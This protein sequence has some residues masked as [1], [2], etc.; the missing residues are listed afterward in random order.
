MNIFRNMIFQGLGQP[1]A[2]T[3]GELEAL[4]SAHALQPCPPL[5]LQTA[6]WVPQENGALV[7]SVGRHLFCTLG[8]ETKVL[9]ASAI[10][11]EVDK[12]AS[13]I[14]PTYGTKPGRKWRRECK[15]RVLDRLLPQAL[16]RRRNIRVWIDGGRGRIVTDA[17]SG[18]MH[19]TAIERLREAVGELPIHPFEAKRTPYGL[20]TAW[21]RSGSGSEAFVIGEDCELA[22]LDPRG[23]TARYRQIPLDDFNVKRFLND[24][25]VVRKLALQ[26]REKLSFV[27]DEHLRIHRLNW[28]DMQDLDGDYESEDLRHEAELIAMTGECCEL[29]DALQDAVGVVR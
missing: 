17:A 12:A 15:T 24:G 7:Q 13:E 1:W 3:P 5:A 28:M 20:M 26:W 10:Q 25:F 11:Q 18:A 23:S 14:E 2:L 9:P 6:G 19:D 16:T 21:L 4:L 27:L 22:E 29:I 8:I